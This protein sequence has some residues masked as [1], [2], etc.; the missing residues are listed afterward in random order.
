MA[1]SRS[2]SRSGSS[3]RRARSAATASRASPRP[4]RPLREPR[5]REPLLRARQPRLLDEVA[6]LVAVEPVEVGDAH[7]HGR[8]AVPVRRREVDA[9]RV[10]EE[11][12]LHAEVG[13]AEDEHVVEALARVGVDGVRPAAAVEAEHLAVHL[14]DGPPVLDLLRRL[15]HAER[16]LVEIL[17]RRHGCDTRR[18]GGVPERSNGAVLKTVEPHGS[19]S[20]NLTPAARSS[21]RRRQLATPER[22]PA[23]ARASDGDTPRT[24]ARPAGPSISTTRER[25][26][27]RARSPW[28]PSEPPSANQVHATSR[29]KSRLRVGHPSTEPRLHWRS[30]AGTRLRPTAHRRRPCAARRRSS[31]R[32]RPRARGDARRATSRDRTV[33]ARG[34]DPRLFVRT[35]GRHVPPRG[36]RRSARWPPTPSPLPAI[37]PARRSRC[38]PTEP[39]RP[40]RDRRSLPRGSRAGRRGSPRS[41]PRFIEPKSRGV[42]T[43]AGSGRESDRV[44]V[45]PDVG[46]Q[47][48]E[49][50]LERLLA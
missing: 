15:G 29:R 23:D 50:D 17:H 7:E 43:G 28:P 21:V 45:E 37:R 12:L 36:A 8:V 14:V 30:A 11:Q 44:S 6:Q 19:V 33:R 1:R 49:R 32:R 25:I 4:A 31:A 5:L 16:E 38:L 2:R 24:A 34:S 20:S 47:A 40:W 42:S 10:G 41:D 35:R 46:W 27:V 3:A 39:T 26:R 13:D 22:A 48:G 9:A 18:R